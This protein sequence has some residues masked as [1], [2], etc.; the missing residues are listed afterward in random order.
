MVAKIS[1]GSSLFGAL[2][3]NQNKVDKEQGKVLAANKI[4]QPLD[5]HFDLHS[6]MN[7]FSQQLPSDCKTEKPVIHISLNP[8][9][10]DVLTDEELTTI[11]EEYMKRLG[12]GNQPYMIFKHEDISRRHIHIVSLRVDSCGKKINDKFEHIRSKEI[13]R[14]LEKEYGLFP[15]E[16]KQ[17]K[18][19]WHTTPIDYRQGNLKHQ[20]SNTLK[21]L[22]RMYRFQSLNEYRALLSF[23]RVGVEEVKGEVNQRSYNGLI[24]SVLNEQGEKI[25][26]PFKASLLDKSLGYKGIQEHITES[27]NEIKE[28]LLKERIR[29]LVTTTWQSTHS[30]TKFIAQLKKNGIDVL[31]RRNKTG[32]IYG[33]TFIDHQ[34]HVALNGSRLGKNYSAN[35][36]NDLFRDIQSHDNQQ[37][38]PQQMSLSKSSREYSTVDSEEGSLGSILSLLTPDTQS[39]DNDYTVPHW[40]KKRKKRRPGQQF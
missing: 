1:I 14:A 30:E 31:F 28:K 39:S 38:I 16:R 10:D 2:S 6:C 21:P 19:E 3:Y 15:A 37:S 11:G 7:C 12:Y 24:Y 23:Y 32:R 36:F 9:P 18:E 27:T 13:T 5:G 40:K 4:M 17:Q 8:H 34:S 25:G 26:T 35:V 22:V 20:L 33:V 29:S